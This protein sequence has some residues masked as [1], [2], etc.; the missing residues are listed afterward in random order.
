MRTTLRARASVVGMTPP[1]HEHRAQRRRWRIGTPLVF[2]VSGALFLVSANNSEGTDLRPGR[3]N[4]LAGIVRVEDRH[5]K[6]LEARAARLSREI[7]RLSQSID[8][9]AVRRAREEAAKVKG[10]AGLRQVRGAGIT[11]VLS[12]AP[13]EVQDSSSQKP[14]TLVVHQQDISAVLNAM[15]AAGATAV[16]IQGQRVVSTTGIKCAGATV[17]VNGRYFPQPYVISA[18]GDPDAI[19]ARID[20][21]AY[22]SEYRRQSEV[23]DIQIGW[24]SRVETDLTAPAYDGLLTLDYAV[25]EA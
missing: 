24:E 2:A 21:D 4:D 25:P 23:E 6:E 8:D 11:V 9:D 1:T 10:P 14:N 13:A 20:A 12:D 22:I 5:L 3:T 16:T 17:Q 19:G 18:I 15:W 7:D